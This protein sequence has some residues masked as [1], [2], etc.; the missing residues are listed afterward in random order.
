MKNVTIA[1]NN[2]VYVGKSLIECYYYKWYSVRFLSY[3]FL[4]GRGFVKEGVLC[5]TVFISSVNEMC[6]EC[7]ET[8]VKEIICFN[9]LL[10]KFPQFPWGM[11]KEFL[12]SVSFSNIGQEIQFI[13][14]IMVIKNSEVTRPFIR[15]KKNKNTCDKEG[16][17][18]NATCILIRQMINMQSN[19]L[20]YL[21]L[22]KCIYE[23][24]PWLTREQDIIRIFG[25]LV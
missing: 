19:F 6:G 23:H 1:S 2:M 14:L 9:T 21:H 25:C 16:L 8:F 15:I 3:V 22:W 13:L 18:W 5:E 11:L 10:E 24:D 4:W 17:K 20:M 12:I 7:V